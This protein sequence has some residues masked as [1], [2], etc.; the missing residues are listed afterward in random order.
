[1]QQGIGAESRGSKGVKPHLRRV[2]LDEV[3][4]ERILRAGAGQPAMVERC[5]KLVAGQERAC[6]ADTHRLNTPASTVRHALAG[7][8]GENRHTKALPSLNCS[9][10]VSGVI[11]GY[12][13]H[14]HTT[15]TDTITL[16]VAME[17]DA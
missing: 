7:R 14:I 2:S 17:V 5:R 12:L 15:D 3:A 9:A 8:A 4:K 13:Q 1:M 6:E 11:H 10:L 16:S